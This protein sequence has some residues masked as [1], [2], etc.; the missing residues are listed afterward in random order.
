MGIFFSHEASPA[1]RPSTPD[2]MVAAVVGDVES[3]TGPLATSW[4]INKFLN[5]GRDGAV[6]PIL[7]VNGYKSTI[8]RCW[9]EFRRRLEKFVSWLRLDTVFHFT[10]AQPG[11]LFFP[12]TL[13]IGSF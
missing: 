3:E 11:I 4:H 9:H 8:P 13:E 10:P 5:P 6:L 1:E 2:L 12:D 7:H